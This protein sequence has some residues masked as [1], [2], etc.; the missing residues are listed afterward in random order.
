MAQEQ[1]K[2]S[3]RELQLSWIRKLCEFY[4]LPNGTT[5]GTKRCSILGSGCKPARLDESSLFCKICF[6]YLKFNSQVIK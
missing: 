3:S 6:I 5:T 2:Q 1:Q 4:Q